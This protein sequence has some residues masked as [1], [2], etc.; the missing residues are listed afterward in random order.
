MN[1]RDPT[2]LTIIVLS[3][4]FIPLAVFVVALAT[5]D[6]SALMR[7]LAGLRTYGVI[8]VVGL[9]VLALIAIGV[10]VLRPGGR[11]S[12]SRVCPRCGEELHRIH[13]T[14]LDKLISRFVHVHRYRC[15][16]PRCRWEGV[17]SRSHRPRRESDAPEQSADAT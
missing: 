2:R 15:A 16:N 4:I 6:R 9:I 8:I 7:L 13:R 12:A 17:V 3:L 5:A 11:P 10:F 1:S 14:P